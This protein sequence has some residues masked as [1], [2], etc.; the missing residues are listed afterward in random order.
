ML[1]FEKVWNTILWIEHM[2]CT[3][4]SYQKICFRCANFELW[5]ITFEGLHI[6]IIQK[7]KFQKMYT[8]IHCNLNINNISFELFYLENVLY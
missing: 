1:H 4:L 7:F 5:K 8:K 6:I 2:Q 3:L